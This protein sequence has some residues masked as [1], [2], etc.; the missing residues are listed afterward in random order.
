MIKRWAETVVCD[1]NVLRSMKSPDFVRTLKLPT[2]KFIKIH[3]IM[4]T[5]SPHSTDSLCWVQN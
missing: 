5:Y 2:N 1:K 3:Q 4:I